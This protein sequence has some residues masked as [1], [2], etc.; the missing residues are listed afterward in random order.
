LTELSKKS[1]RSMGSGGNKKLPPR[2][3][4]T[5]GTVQEFHCLSTQPTPHKHHHHGVLFAHPT[6]LVQS[7]PPNRLVGRHPKGLAEGAI[8]K[9]LI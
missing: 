4:P 3:F 6:A 2:R 8:T 7:I 9:K 1:I 5:V